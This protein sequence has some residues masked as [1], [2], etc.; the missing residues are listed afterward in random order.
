MI[1]EFS[2]ALSDLGVDRHYMY[3]EVYFNVRYR[4]DPAVVAAIRDRFTASDLFAPHAHIA[5]G[6][7]LPQRA[8][9][10]T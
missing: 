3:E 10:R 6:L 1:E 9:D 8:R 7:F 2:T 4:A 5:A